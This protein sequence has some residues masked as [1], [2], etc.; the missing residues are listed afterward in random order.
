MEIEIVTFV[1][2]GSSKLTVERDLTCMFTTPIPA[3][4]HL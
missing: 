2:K 4:C 3:S 1:V